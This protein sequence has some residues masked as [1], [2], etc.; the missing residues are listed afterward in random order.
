MSNTTICPSRNYRHV[1]TPTIIQMESVESGP[2]CLSIIAAHYGKSVPI[3]ELRVI[4]GVSRDGSSALSILEGGEKLG[5]NVKYFN[6]KE[7]NKLYETL[8]TPLI[9]NWK[10]THFVVLEGYGA[11]GVFINDPETGPRVVSYEEFNISFTGIALY[12]KP[13]SNF[14][15]SKTSSSL[16]S[17]LNKRLKGVK[18][19]LLFA[20]F[21]GL[22]VVLPKVALPAMMQL[23]IDQV[24]IDGYTSWIPYL[25]QALVF[26]IFFSFISFGIQGYVLNRLNI[27]LSWTLYSKFFWRSLDLPIQFFMQRGA[28]N[29]AKVAEKND[30]I[31]KTITGTLTKTVI[32]CLLIVV[33]I[34]I[35]L[36]YDIYIA[37]VVLFGIAL[38]LFVTHKLNKAR[39]DAHA[40]YLAESIK[41]ESYSINVVDS[42]ETVKSSGIESTVF[43]KSMGYYTKNLNN[44][45][46]IKTKD[47]Y[48]AE[49]PSLITFCID[50]F[51]LT[52]GAWRIM[53]GS[54]TIGMLIALRVLMNNIM[55][56]LTSLIRFSNNIQTL[57]VNLNRLDDI[58]KNKTDPFVSKTKEKTQNSERL[59]LKLKGNIELSN[60]SFSYSPIKPPVVNSINFSLSAGKN[61]A[62]V[63]RSGSGK[64]TIAKVILGLLPYT[65][66]KI[67]ID[68]TPL[69]EI[70]LNILSK[71]T[72]LVMKGGYIF[73][74]TIL[75]NITLNDFTIDETEVIKAAKDALVHED[76]IARPP[77]Y[78]GMVSAKGR[79]LSAGQM[80]KILIARSLVRNPSVLVLD[81]ATSAIDLEQ[82]TAILQNIKRR[83]CTCLIIAQR[84]S[85]IRSCDEVI[86]IEKGEIA[87]KGLHKDLIIQPGFYQNLLTPSLKETHGA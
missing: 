69:N 16:F 54:M 57:Q 52:F 61:L 35:M 36:A 41:H 49:I 22:L 24:L 27:K 13:G 83:G 7:L 70:P 84:I 43:S 46:E 32:Q 86:V 44:L 30:I 82:E 19:E 21:S 64:S 40:R 65:K 3:D 15:K 68:G 37:S 5:F 71:T 74:G 14:T 18:K 66:G 38:I 26:L 31:A 55:V 10:T 48:L 73:N 63:G 79:D 34:A 72:G 67:S 42:I 39:L 58:Q 78:E 11:N 87:Q 2:T 29:L 80:Q 51:L 47:I 53:Q 59:P 28:G 85:T 25:L 60:V 1:S 45:T 81:E 62:V 12:L 33:Y 4:C 17:S 50:I 77:G 8:A 23:F 20:L 75:Q 9:I 76:I 56:P 6:I